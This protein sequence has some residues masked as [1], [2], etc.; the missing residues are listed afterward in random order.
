MSPTVALRHLHLLLLA[1]L[2]LAC[3]VISSRITSEA[4]AQP[5]PQP[6]Q[7]SVVPTPPQAV[8][9]P[10]VSDFP[11]NNPTEGQIFTGVG[12]TTENMNAS[13]P[14]ALLARFNDHPLPPQLFEARAA[15][16]P[17][18]AFRVIPDVE[19]LASQIEESPLSSEPSRY[20]SHTP[21]ALRFEDTLHRMAT[22]RDVRSDEPTQHVEEALTVAGFRRG[23]QRQEIYEELHSRLVEAYRSWALDRA[24][25]SR[26]EKGRQTS[27]LDPIFK[28][29]AVFV[30]RD[31]ARIA[32]YSDSS[33]SAA[34][35]LSIAND[36]ELTVPRDT[37]LLTYVLARRGQAA[38]VFHPEQESIPAFVGWIDASLTGSIHGDV[39]QS[40]VQPPKNYNELAELELHARRYLALGVADP[41][42]QARA[43]A[44]L[45][46]IML[47][48]APDAKAELDTD[49]DAWMVPTALLSTLELT[50]LQWTLGSVLNQLES[51]PRVMGRPHSD[52]FRSS[53]L[54][55]LKQS[56]RPVNGDKSTVLSAELLRT[57]RDSA[58]QSF[59]D[60][61]ER[62]CD[63][64]PERR[65]SASQ[66]AATLEA[67][68]SRNNASPGPDDDPLWRLLA[69]SKLH[70]VGP[71]SVVAAME[72][73]DEAVASALRGRL[74]TLMDWSL[75]GNPYVSAMAQ[76]ELELFRRATPQG[77]LS[78][79]FSALPRR[80]LRATLKSTQE[81]LDRQ[82][83]IPMDWPES[84]T[85]LRQV[86]A[87]REH[88]NRTLSLT[89]HP[90]APEALLAKVGNIVLS[91]APEGWAS[92]VSAEDVRI[93]AVGAPVATLQRWREA[94]TARE[95]SL[96]SVALPGQI[97]RVQA[98]KTNIEAA[99]SSRGARH[100]SW[101]VW[102][103]LR[104][105]EVM[106][107]A[108][109]E[110]LLSDQLELGLTRSEDRASLSTAAKLLRFVNIARPH[111]FNDDGTLHS[112][113]R[114]QVARGTQVT[115]VMRGLERHNGRMWLVLKQ[116][117]V[118]LG[119][120]HLMVSHDVLQLSEVGNDYVIEQL[121]EDPS[122]DDE[123]VRDVL[124]DIEGGA[125]ASHRARSY[126]SQGLSP[127]FSASSSML[128]LV[129]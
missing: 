56:P 73:G 9:E 70:A 109:F 23:Q 1:T 95:A 105:E 43:V 29:R 87:L 27:Y 10:L 66:V 11:A 57:A 71:A 75:E 26:G 74:R 107:S 113:Q 91:D 94:L 84:Q 128:R 58:L 52:A 61:V 104:L 16:P 30:T 80:D 83:A 62:F 103:A 39:V 125:R 46:W 40:E 121:E 67:I 129:R 5:W 64:A 18:L 28:D 20:K 41:I 124:N 96:S 51:T 98:L 7:P 47:L 42:R 50:E 65:P 111:L 31:P 82:Q 100:M 112:A 49:P 59:R 115:Q 122:L 13:I 3:G 99:L 69:R 90:P 33:Q 25:A 14:A 37:H 48:V 116:A 8:H 119:P 114:Q 19:L 4:R 55:H 126:H 78:T 88:L 102:F 120:Q 12:E 54:A 108:Q 106:K 24:R 127:V 97:E 72:N 89:P 2:L 81:W 45:R 38:L 76:A 68:R 117:R 21:E 92:L 53:L 85:R 118:E 22:G 34:A 32:V 60:D 6:A 36:P 86:Q 123:Y 63:H 15:A 44:T 17:P 77:D 110:S 101:G 79:L 35:R 93:A